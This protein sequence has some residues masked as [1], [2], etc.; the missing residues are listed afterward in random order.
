MDEPL[1]RRSRP[2]PAVGNHGRGAASTE[3]GQGRLP[4]QPV[5]SPPPP[6][7]PEA[8]HMSV[9]RRAGAS[10]NHSVKLWSAHCRSLAG[11]LQGSRHLSGHPPLDVSSRSDGSGGLVG[12]VAL[13]L[14]RRDLTQQCRQRHQQR[15]R[16]GPGLVRD[17][18]Q[19]PLPR[20]L[21]GDAA[22]S[23]GRGIR[24]HRHPPWRSR[25]P[26][27]HLRGGT[28]LIRPPTHRGQHV[29]CH[30]G[31][32]IRAGHTRIPTCGTDRR[33]GRLDPPPRGLHRHSGLRALRSLVPGA[34]Q[35][36]QGQIRRQLA[37]AVEHRQPRRRHVPRAGH[38]V[39]QQI[40]DG[41][42]LNSTR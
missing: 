9:A 34:Q 10:P 13:P 33:A 39:P 40:P 2:L 1:C 12:P 16:S 24:P 25:R 36:W 14:P 4:P 38:L 6:A 35:P 7:Q 18:E 27:V 26:V 20:Q 32:T 29:P 30:V 3:G 15:H 22:Q 28:Q 42:R 37:A 21:A 5:R 11:P 23:R 17:P 41:A 8:S 19:P 31:D